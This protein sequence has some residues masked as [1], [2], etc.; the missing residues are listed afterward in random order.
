MSTELRLGPTSYLVLGLVAMSGPSTPY[1]LKRYVQLSVGNFWPFPHTQLY[2]EPARLAEAGLLEETREQTGRRRR[3]YTITTAGSQRLSEWLSEPVSSPT[4]YR[5]LGLLK[6]FFAELA[7]PGDVIALAH[8]QAAAQRR[9]LAHY[10]AILERFANRP[11]QAK[12]ARVAELGV[13]LARTAA[14]FWEDIVERET[15]ADA[16]AA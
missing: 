12:R 3:H 8:E 10:D 11:A 13:R 5:D 15:R 16:D 1:D 7:Q 9:Q 2:A 14:E 6:F 4:E